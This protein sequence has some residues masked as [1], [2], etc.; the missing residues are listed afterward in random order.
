MKEWKNLYRGA[1]NA[2]K[3]L[4]IDIETYEKNVFDYHERDDYERKMIYKNGFSKSVTL[5]SHLLEKNG[6]F[7]FDSLMKSKKVWTTIDGVRMYIIPK[8]ISVE[9]DQ[10]YNDI[11]RVKLTYQYSDE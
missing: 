2:M 3:N 4:S 9:E 8:S 7:L 11:Y 10:A 1:Q 5:Q 6:K